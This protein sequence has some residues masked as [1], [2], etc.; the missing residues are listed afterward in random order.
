M[1][2]LAVLILMLTLLLTGCGNSKT[3]DRESK[4]SSDVESVASALE[5]IAPKADY[6]LIPVY[7][8]DERSVYLNASV[9]PLMFFSLTCP[10]CIEELPKVQEI[11]QDLKP[12]KPLVYVATFFKT[13]NLQEAIE[14]TKEF[15]KE[16]NINGTVVIQAGPPKAYVEKV[17][18][19]VT[20]QKGK[21]TPEIITGMPSKETLAEVLFHTDN[22]GSE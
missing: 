10:A 15:I 16:H 6:E 2:K 18:S 12:Q 20:L 11:V 14:Q 21:G 4:I 1:K 9:T 7:T 19:L 8:L 13:A 17:P 5:A 3:E 22:K